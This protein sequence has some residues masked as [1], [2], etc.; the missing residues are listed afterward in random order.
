[1]RNLFDTLTYFEIESE[2]LHPLVEAEWG[3][4][5]S[6]EVPG[7]DSSGHLTFSFDK[8]DLPYNVLNQ[9][10]E[11]FDQDVQDLIASSKEGSTYASN[12]LIS[13]F[14]AKQIRDGKLDPGNYKV[15][16]SWG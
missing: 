12:E 15:Y 3:C 14:L 5:L 4:E 1:M 11:L 10:Q 6:P 9:P 16:Y 8:N 7:D 13:M 2:Q